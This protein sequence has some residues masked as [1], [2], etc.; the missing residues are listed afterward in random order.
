MNTFSGADGTPAIF[1]GGTF[2]GNP[3]TMSAGIAALSF[4]KENKK[5]V[6][7][8]FTRAGKSIRQGDKRILRDSQHSRKTHECRIYDALVVW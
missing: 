2:N 5:E 6:Y 8:F 3:L 7:P 1:A 4:L